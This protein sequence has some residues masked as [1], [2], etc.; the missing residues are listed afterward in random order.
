MEDSEGSN[1]GVGRFISVRNPRR[2][3]H[4]G[5]RERRKE[6]KGSKC[7]LYLLVVAAHSLRPQTAQF[8]GEVQKAAVHATSYTSLEGS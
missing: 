1:L 8:R 7:M 5:K 4:D 3:S 6:R 2:N